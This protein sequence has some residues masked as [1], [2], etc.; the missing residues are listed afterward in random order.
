MILSFDI[1]EI[2]YILMGVWV[3]LS[4]IYIWW[5]SSCSRVIKQCADDEDVKEVIT[6]PEE[7]PGVSVIVYD[8]NDAEYLR[9]NLP[10]LLNQ[11]YPRFEVIIVNDGLADDDSNIVSE[12]R[13]Q[14]SNIYLTFVPNDARNVS[15]KKLALMVGI[16]AAKYDI[17]VTTNANCRPESP[18]WLES[19]ARNF[20]SG[21]DVVIGQ[22]K[23]DFATDRKFGRW[24]RLFDNVSTRILYL[25]YAINGKPYRGTSDNLAYRRQIFFA[26]KG[27][28]RS[29]NL[30]YGDDDIF[31]SEIA[32]ST[33]TRVELSADSYITAEYDNVANT[34]HE[35]KMRYD[36]TSRYIDTS[37]FTTSGFMAAVYYLDFLSI[38]ALVA[39]N[40]INIIVI[41][42]A[43][44]L[45]LALTMPQI[46]ILRS[47]ARQLLAPRMFFAL[48]L[49]TLLRPLINLRYRLKGQRYRTQNFTWQRIK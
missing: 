35:R 48:P 31:V 5:I 26:N 27:F 37:A 49:F 44:L 10:F 45:V 40:Y 23:Y 18:N 16:K 41:G 28:S 20:V 33:N 39:I 3:L 8:H 25:S 14:H 6:A 13:V 24:Y 43:L 2:A 12:F 42:I 46:F 9:Q 21:I 15:R 17:I 34:A 4:I 19:I 22:S 30:H 1:S 47:A 38:A 29:M 11:E 7:L 32:D 36:F